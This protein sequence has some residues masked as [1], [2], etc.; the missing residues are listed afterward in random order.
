M[1]GSVYPALRHSHKGKIQSLL[2]R[3]PSLPNPEPG[4]ASNPLPILFAVLSIRSS[5]NPPTPSQPLPSSR[6]NFYTSSLSIS[7]FPHSPPLLRSTV[8][9]R[10]PSHP[11]CVFS[12]VFLK[13][14]RLSRLLLPP[15]IHSRQKRRPL[16][17]CRKP[18][19]FVAIVS[20][21]AWSRPMHLSFGS[22]CQE[23]TNRTVPRILFAPDPL[24]SA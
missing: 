7:L 22:T 13:P 14:V 15:P 20:Q 18:R 12:S 17:R 3:D 11:A 2:G 16:T 4:S 23:L 9:L 21:H 6:F 5:T 1:K 19:N 8:H 24:P 10:L